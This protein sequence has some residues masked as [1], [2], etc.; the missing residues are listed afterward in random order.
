MNKVII[1]KILCVLLLMITM[2]SSCFTLISSAHSNLSS[3]YLQNIGQADYHL[4]YDFNDGGSYVIC[5]IV[6]HY[7]DDI[8][9]PAYCLNRDLKGTQK[10]EQYEVRIDDVLDN[11]SVWRVLTNGYPYKSAESM[12]LSEYDAFCVTKMA[13]YCVLGQSDINKYSVDS[14]DT[15]AVHM[16]NKLRELVDIGINGSNT[17]QEGTL[18]SNKIGELKETDNY[19]Y[20][21]Y[22]ISSVVEISNY[23]IVNK[24]GFSEGT[25]IANTNGIECSTFN[26]G[27]NFRIYIPKSDLYNNI[28][29]AVSIN[30]KAKTYPI[31]YGEHSDPS[32]QD[33]VLT[34]DPYGD[35]SIVVDMKLATNTGKIII[36]KTD[37]YT[38]QPISGVVFGLYR[39]DGT[40][41][42][43]AT[44]NEK[45]VAIFNNL[46]QGN[47]ILK[48]IST[49]SEYI[50]N[51]NDFNVNVTFNKTETINLENEHKKGNLKI[52]K[53]DR[54][55]NKISLG[56]VEFELYN[57]ELKKVIGKYKTDYN[58]EIF[59]E[60][61][62]TGSYKLHE[63]ETNKW[64]NLGE[65]KEI[66]IFWNDTTEETIENELKKSKVKIIKVD[67]D[68]NEIKLSGVKFEVLDDKNNIL[69]IVET[70]ENGEA[71]TSEY[72]VRE[73]EKLYLRE[74]ETLENYVLNDELTEIVLEENQIK[75]VTFEN[76]KIKGSIKILK[77]SNGYNQV[78]NIDDGTPLK[79]AKFVIV[80][81]FGEIIG[82]Y[83][84][85]EK[86]LIQI[87]NLLYGEY[88]IYEYDVP[89]G[90]LKD[91]EPQKVFINKNGQITSV[92]FKNSPIEPE[93]PKT[94]V[95]TDVTKIFVLVLAV[96]SITI[97]INKLR[98]MEE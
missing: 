35:E 69:E 41:I 78:L 34:S 65:D 44:T 91:A 3:A 72:S 12:G 92:T 22:S 86:G 36:N 49:N 7:I 37:D 81:S 42:S 67:K 60:N 93:L 88:T 4:K 11:D 20:Q 83:E 2:F 87:D 96:T 48:E 1:K 70:N 58:G 82:V 39:K 75:T 63:I 27:E 29:G 43:R 38:K 85:D 40:E 28:N 90:Y 89:E 10:D 21:E 24:A 73:Y 98:K 77:V 23:T 18:T 76:E 95:D 57:N 9:Y 46:Y 52:F 80:N 33:Y 68:N 32:R 97:L 51:K 94:G 53:V 74:K 5:S 84:T 25:F 64:Y 61:L 79:G 16:L 50:L 30:A 54:D 56:G 17:M 47:Y 55:D 62:R 66:A 15:I 31:L 6:G 71:I 19:Y 8:F 13:V 45:G 14:D 59:I 26:M